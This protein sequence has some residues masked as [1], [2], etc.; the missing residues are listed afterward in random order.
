MGR[1]SRLHVGVGVDK[2][3][4]KLFS[5]YNSVYVRHASRDVLNTTI[6][7]S[8]LKTIFEFHS[9]KEARVCK[10]SMSK[11]GKNSVSKRGHI[12][13]KETTV[14]ERSKREPLGEE[15]N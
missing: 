2:N 9:L 12:V 7:T 10:H 13:S 5:K 4:V 3:H 15:E 1:F 8:I 6:N 11:W 14:G